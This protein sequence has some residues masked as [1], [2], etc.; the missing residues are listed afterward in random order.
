MRRLEV[1]ISNNERRKTTYERISEKEIFHHNRW[2]NIRRTIRIPYNLGNRIS[3]NITWN[4][5]VMVVFY[6]LKNSD[7]INKVL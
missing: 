3:G 2:D 1:K 7:N 6:Y 5:N 4:F